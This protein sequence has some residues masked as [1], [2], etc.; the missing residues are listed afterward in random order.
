MQLGTVP[1][2]D[3]ARLLQLAL[4][5][6]PAVRHA[7][8]VYPAVHVQVHS[9]WKPDI[10]VARLLQFAAEVHAVL[11]QPVSVFVQLTAAPAAHVTV[12]IWL[13]VVPTLTV[14]ER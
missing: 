7:V 2:H 11:P 5:H 9:G 13:V 3:V 14:V 10:V 6:G 8:P 4:V 1:D 12:L